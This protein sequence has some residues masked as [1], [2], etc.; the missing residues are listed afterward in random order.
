V[1]DAHFCS[2]DQVGDKNGMCLTI[3]KKVLEIKGDEVVVED[4]NKNRQTLKTLV[5]LTIGDF[6]LSQSGVIVERIDKKYAR[7]IM[8]FLNRK[9]KIVS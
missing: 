3:P 5:E 8:G 7:E 1:R 2:P 4:F 9:E 6:V